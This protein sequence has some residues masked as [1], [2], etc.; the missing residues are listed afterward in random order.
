MP[1]LRQLFIAVPV[2]PVMPAFGHLQHLHVQA[3]VYNDVTVTS[4]LHMPELKTLCLESLRADGPHSMPAQIDVLNLQTLRQLQHLSLLRVELGRVLV[5]ESCRVHVTS[6]L[7]TVLS[8]SWAG[9]GAHHITVDCMSAACDQLSE[10]A[11]EMQQAVIA[12]SLQSFS[13][14]AE[15][16]GFPSL[17]FI[18]RGPVFSQITSLTLRM[19]CAL[20]VTIPSCMPLERL[21][22]AAPNLPLA[23]EDLSRFVGRV[24]HLGVWMHDIECLPLF[25]EMH[26]VLSARGLQLVF[27]ENLRWSSHAYIHGCDY[28]FDIRLVAN[29]SDPV[30]VHSVLVMPQAAGHC[31][32]RQLWSWVTSCNLHGG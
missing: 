1:R 13:I 20:V 11:E 29:R 5:V 19:Q 7:Q 12:G 8:G 15:R 32:G 21:L 22:I 14:V 4:L 16:L 31:G 17:P 26:G 30:R 25:D 24:H 10:I 18:V 6:P 2:A 27:G 23:F 28:D 9:I 3:A